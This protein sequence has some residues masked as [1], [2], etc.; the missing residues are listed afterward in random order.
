M[1]EDRFLPLAGEWADQ[2]SPYGPLWEL[3]AA[4]VTAVAGDNLLVGLLTFKLIGLLAHLGIAY[5]LWQALATAPQRAAFTLLWAWNPALLLTFVVSGHN[6]GLMLLLM[7]LGLLSWRRSSPLA[8]WHLTL[9]AL[10]K[11]VA[12]LP[13]PLF[14]AAT[15]RTRRLTHARLLL[16]MAVSALT[17]WLLFLPFGSPLP[18]AL[19]LVR[20]A[21]AVP[22]FSVTT[23]LLL[24]ARALGSTVSLTV[25]GWTARLP[26]AAL[27]LWLLWRTVNGR[28]PTRST[29]DAFGGYLLHALSFRIWYASWLFPAALLDAAASENQYRLRVALL[30]LLTTQLSVLIYGHVRVYLLGG[31]HLW[32][33]LIGVPFTFGLPLLLARRRD[34]SAVP[35]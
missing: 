8:L 1:A 7:A 19:R 13:L 30:F 25:V 29:V 31:S 27:L 4:A 5:T 15:W 28:S 20:E 35:C 14:F 22:G 12:L 11:P 26:F 34:N 23:L 33:H 21:S 2:T 18:L 3:T 32:A 16:I 17:G 9:A 10:V 24:I 6:D